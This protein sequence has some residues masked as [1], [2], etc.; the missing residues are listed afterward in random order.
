MQPF[1]QAANLNFF[2]SH[3]KSQL[4]FSRKITFSS[5]NHAAPLPMSYSIQGWNSTKSTTCNSTTVDH[6]DLNILNVPLVLVAMSATFWKASRNA[7]TANTVVLWGSKQQNIY[8]HQRQCWLGTETELLKINLIHILRMQIK[9]L[10][11]MKRLMWILSKFDAVKSM[12]PEGFSFVILWFRRV[13][14]H[15]T[16]CQSHTGADYYPTAHAAKCRLHRWTAWVEGAIWN[17]A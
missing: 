16:F 9:A 3:F 1:K 4:Q 10:S 5:P 2:L 14:F 8:S 15:L 12:R 13:P 6:R 7:A 17:K 11:R